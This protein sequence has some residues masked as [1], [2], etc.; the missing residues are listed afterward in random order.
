MIHF[1]VSDPSCPPSNSAGIYEY[2]KLLFTRCHP[3]KTDKV[4]EGLQGM[5]GNLVP[6]F[7]VTD[8]KKQADKLLY[9]K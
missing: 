2:K 9:G 4:Q 6:V 1:I 5:S 3:T 7:N 8:Y